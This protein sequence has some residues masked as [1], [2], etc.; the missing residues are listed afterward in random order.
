MVGYCPVH[1]N[2]IIDNKNKPWIQA[3]C[4]YR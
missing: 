1:I 2:V 3:D 4:Y